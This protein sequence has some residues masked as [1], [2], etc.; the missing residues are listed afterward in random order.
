MNG[1]TS[2]D[3]IRRMADRRP[4][5]RRFHVVAYAAAHRRMP[6]GRSSLGEFAGRGVKHSPHEVGPLPWDGRR[7]L[8]AEV[9]EPGLTVGL[10]SLVEL[11]DG[12]HGHL[13]ILDLDVP[14]SDAGAAV[15]A[16]AVQD[17]GDWDHALV[18]TQH[19]YHYYALAVLPYQGWLAFMGRALLLEKITDVRWVG[20]MLIDGYSCLRID[21]SVDKPQV[22]RVVRTTI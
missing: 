16:H 21:Q 11:Q 9:R 8:P 3:L 12:S 13:P 19:S 20:H 5:I 6:A 1:E 14:V 4:D 15:V 2:L 7:S 18:E 10:A 17:L 22:P